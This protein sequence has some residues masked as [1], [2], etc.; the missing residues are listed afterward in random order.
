M[1]QVI[2]DL[3]NILK[4]AGFIQTDSTTGRNKN[5][6]TLTVL[7]TPDAN[8]TRG[9]IAGAKLGVTREIRV[10]LHYVGTNNPEKEIEILEK[11]DS[12]IAEFYKY[13]SGNIVFLNAEILHINEESL[14]EIRFVFNDLITL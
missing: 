11:Q 13:G 5:K 9:T 6:Y 2:Y 14:N 10:I 4:A 7:T 3:K 1:R 8:K 12:I